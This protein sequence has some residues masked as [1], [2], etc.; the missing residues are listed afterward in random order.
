MRFLYEVEFAIEEVIEI[1]Q[2]RI[3]FDDLVC[4]LLERKPDVQSKTF[5]A[6]R[7]ALRRTHDPL[8]A[9]GNDHVIARHHRPREFF[10]DF[11]FR[12]V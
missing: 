10:G 12:C 9:A 7:A 8:P 5:F 4:L 6:A 2:L 1:N 3:A 11:R